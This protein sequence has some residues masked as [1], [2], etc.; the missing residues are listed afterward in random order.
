MK[1]HSNDIK[2]FV[3]VIFLF[4]FYIMYRFKKKVMSPVQCSRW[5]IWT[6]GRQSLG[7]YQT[8]LNTSLDLKRKTKWGTQI[9]CLKWPQCMNSS[10]TH[11]SDVMETVVFCSNDQPHGCIS[12]QSMYVFFLNEYKCTCLVICML[13]D[14]YIYLVICMLLDLYIYLAIHIQKMSFILKQKSTKK[15]KNLY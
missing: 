14:L 8:R 5:K 11:I 9:K 10:T 15:T 6:S 2:F 1:T 3:L 7:K 13:L 12:T 4:C